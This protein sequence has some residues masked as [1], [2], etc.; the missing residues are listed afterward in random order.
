M[1]LN[2]QMK[3][4]PEGTKATINGKKMIKTGGKWIPRNE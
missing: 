1:P 4:A 2:E 3:A